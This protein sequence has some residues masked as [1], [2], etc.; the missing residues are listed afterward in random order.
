MHPSD[1]PLQRLVVAVG[2][3]A[4]LG[5]GGLVVEGVA[6][7]THRHR[8][9]LLDRDHACTLPS[10]A[11]GKPRPGRLWTT[12]GGVPGGGDGTWFAPTGGLAASTG[13]Q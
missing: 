12:A 8:D 9:Q 11:A 13:V 10:P 7:M 3:L 1:G 4:E 6:G 5:D 2:E